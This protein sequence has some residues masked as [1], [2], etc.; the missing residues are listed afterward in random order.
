MYNR[1]QTKKDETC[2]KEQGD[3][4]SEEKPEYSWVEASIEK[5]KDL[6]EYKWRIV[7]WDFKRPQTHSSYVTLLSDII[8]A[9]PSIYEK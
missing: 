6:E 8:D 3:D 2:S 4:S 1:L 5:E 7:W 9:D